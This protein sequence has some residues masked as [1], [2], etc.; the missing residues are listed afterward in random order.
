[1]IDQQDALWSSLG[2]L[3]PPGCLMLGLFGR[4]FNRTNTVEAITSLASPTSKEL[5]RFSFVGISFNLQ[6]ATSAAD[7]HNPMILFFDG[8]RLESGFGASPIRISVWCSP[9]GVFFTEKT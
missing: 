4:A 6:T 9:A 3:M 5:S 2:C 7:L 8:F 1:M